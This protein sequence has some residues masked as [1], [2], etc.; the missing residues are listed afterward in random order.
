MTVNIFNFFLSFLWF[1]TETN[2]T[3]VSLGRKCQIFNTNN[4]MN[5]KTFNRGGQNYASPALEVLE[6]DVEN[7]ICQD[8]GKFS[9]NDWEEDGDG[10]D[11]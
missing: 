2:A 5:T 4:F 9:I 1:S 8:S 6:L 3:F 10:L 7:C 11:F